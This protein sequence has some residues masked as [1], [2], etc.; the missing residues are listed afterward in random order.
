[1][2]YSAKYSFSIKRFIK[3]DLCFCEECLKGMYNEIA[4]LQTPKSLKSPFKLNKK[5]REKDDN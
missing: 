2:K 3:K 4:K 5:L 1:M